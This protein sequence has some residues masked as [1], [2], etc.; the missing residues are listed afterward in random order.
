MAVDLF[1]RRHGAVADAQAVQQRDELQV[2]LPEDLVQFDVRQGNVLQGLGAEEVGARVAPGGE[3][4]ALR[5]RDHRRQLEHVPQQQELHAAERPRAPLALPEKRV[6][7]VED[8]GP[9]HGDFVDDDQFQSLVEPGVGRHA[10]VAQI[11]DARRKAEERVD[12]GAAGIQR[13][14]AGRS[15]HDAPEVEVLPQVADEGR[16]AGAGV[17]R[18]EHQRSAGFEQALH[19]DV[20]VGDD[21]RRRDEPR[22]DA[23]GSRDGAGCA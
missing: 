4:V 22:G 13:R 20:A 23:I 7:A 21:H 11:L 3:Y 15:Q 14:H 16:L 10:D 17:A 1:H 19:L 9:H 5:A 12:G 8:V 2:G 18:D 6:D